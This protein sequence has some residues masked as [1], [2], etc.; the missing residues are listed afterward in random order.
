[1]IDIYFSGMTPTTLSLQNL[2]IPANQAAALRLLEQQNKNVKTEPS[3]PRKRS[4]AEDS[5][6]DREDEGDPPEKKSRSTSN[7]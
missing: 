1:M 6:D 2:L 5:D 4:S 3:S 7:R